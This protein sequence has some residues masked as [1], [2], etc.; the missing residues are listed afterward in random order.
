MINA[1][2]LA[3]KL[4][5]TD[6]PLVLDVRWKLG[7]ASAY[8]EYLAAHI[9][10]AVFV[11]LEQDLCGPPGE[12]G[13]HP[14]PDLAELQIALRAAGV[15]ANREVVVYDFGDG[16]AAARA[17]WTLRWAGHPRVQVLDGGFPAWAASGE[18]TTDTPTVVEPGD[19]EVQPGGMPMLD[20]ASAAS[21]AQSSDGVL[22]DARVP[23]RFRGETEPIDAVAGHI[24]G[25]LNLPYGKLV[26]ADGTL[27]KDL[28]SVLPAAIHVGAYCGSGI[29]AAHTVL[30]LHQAGH[31][32]AALY[33]GSWS[34]WITDKDRPIATGPAS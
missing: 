5:S 27:R 26:N 8:P 28:V 3:A 9:P 31:E 34:H 17:W 20:A 12:G 11:D 10:G 14:L 22:L 23:E 25:A 33:V 4:A 18:P 30:A 32:E 1:A 15:T 16:M 21:L 24:P 2:D 6:P 7:G 19:F 13:R 29:T